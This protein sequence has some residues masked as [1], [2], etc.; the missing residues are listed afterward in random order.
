MT[1]TLTLQDETCAA[2]LSP[3]E[4]R[5]DLA[6]SMFARGALSK[7]SAAALAGLDFFRFQSALAERRI[8]AYTDE[9]LDEDMR[10]LAA[11]KTQ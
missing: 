7:L 1:L 3:E 2:D 11:L 9:M 5:V 10:H 6:C 8:S 4:A